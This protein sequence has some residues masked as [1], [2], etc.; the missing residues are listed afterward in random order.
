MPLTKGHGNVIN[1]SSRVFQ[2]G[3]Q[4]QKVVDGKCS[5]AASPSNQS[6]SPSPEVKKN[7]QQG[8]KPKARFQL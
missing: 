4:D 2:M 3:W 7:R 8:K 1:H 5:F 6:K